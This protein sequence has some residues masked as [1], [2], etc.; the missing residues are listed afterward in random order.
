[1]D[2]NIKVKIEEQ[3]KYADKNYSHCK[4][5][6]DRNNKRYIYKYFDMSTAIECLSKG[7]LRFAEPSRWKDQYEKLFYTADYSNV[8]TTKSFPKQLFACCFTKE[9]VSEA[10]WKTYSYGKTGLGNLCV[11]FKINRSKFRQALNKFLKNKGM[12]Y[13][14]QCYYS[15]SDYDIDRIAEKKSPYYS[16]FFQNGI[17]LEGYLSLLL[18]K[19]SCFKYE[20]EC[21]FFLIPQANNLM[22][23]RG[24]KGKKYIDVNLNWKDFVEEVIVDERCDNSELQVITKAC[25]DAGIKVKPRRNDLYASHSLHL[26]LIIQ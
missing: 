6:G 11:Q 20:N 19:R 2:N 16:V 14:G 23:I 7:D 12:S 15:L 8:D 1:M 17:D 18:I 24:G 10:A 21:R 5:L 22:K 25:K 13:E 9:R 26:P 3:T 4:I